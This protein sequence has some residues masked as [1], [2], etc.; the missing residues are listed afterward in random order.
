MSYLDAAVN[1]N[2]IVPVKHPHITC[3]Y[4]VFPWLHPHIRAVGD[5]RIKLLQ[6]AHRV[7]AVIDKDLVLGISCIAGV[8][9]ETRKV[10]NA[11]DPERVAVEV[12]RRSLELNQGSSLVLVTVKDDFLNRLVILIILDQG[13]EELVHHTT[14]HAMSIA[15]LSTFLEMFDASLDEV[16]VALPFKL[17]STRVEEL[18]ETVGV[19]DDLLPFRSHRPNLHLGAFVSPDGR[20]G[21]S[22]ELLA[23]L[24]NHGLWHDH[25]AD[26]KSSFL[27]LGFV[28]LHEEFTQCLSN[29][30]V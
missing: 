1:R 29:V 11:V 30:G 6:A 25:I 8:H 18:D 9:D 19:V 16:G 14:F 24:G 17:C 22:E 21:H 23:A 28:L 3:P 13:A 7:P 5:A 12:S 20:G 27:P 15:G 10:A 4:G 26:V 2:D